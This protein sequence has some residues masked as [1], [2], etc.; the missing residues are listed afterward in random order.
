MPKLILKFDNR[1]LNEVVVGAR[2]V[3][4]GRL[5]DNALVIDNA[6]VP[7]HHA[8]VFREGDRVVLEDLK[9]TNGTFVHEQRITRHVLSDGDLV[10]IGKHTVSF[11][12]KAGGAEAAEV[13]QPVVPELGGTVM[14]NSKDHQA[15]MARFAPQGSAGAPVVAGTRV[16]VLHAVVDGVEREFPLRDATSFIGKSDTALVRLKGWFKPKVAL[17]IARKRDSYT[18][19]PMQGKTIVNGQRVT[20][21]HELKDGDMLQVSGLTLE[22]RMK[23]T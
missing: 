15:L 11:D 2:P 13:P 16:G 7:G 3:T 23:D 1:V 18:A 5:P 4:I 6:A 19:T 22:F 8:R 9:S 10:R 20:G 21:R 14:L 17:A 12:A